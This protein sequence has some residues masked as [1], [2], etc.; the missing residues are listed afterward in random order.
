MSYSVISWGWAS[1]EPHDLVHILHPRRQHD[2][3]KQVILPDALA[4][5]KAI[6]I[7]QH[8]VQNRQIQAFPLYTGQCV[9]G[10]VELVDDITF[11]FQIDLHE[12]RDGGFVV[13]N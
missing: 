11:V 1:P 2:N 4:E 6:H 3:G 9:C 10:V 12:I 5:G 7:R 8:H 13:Y